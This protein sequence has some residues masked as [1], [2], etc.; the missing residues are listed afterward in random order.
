MTFS[1]R[2]TIRVLA[3]PD[4]RISC[5]RR[6]WRHV[7]EELRLR[8]EGCH[9]SGAFLLGMERRGRLQVTD[10]IFYD[11]LDSNAY[12]TGACV[13]HG[14][15]FGKL[16]AMCRDRD[17]TVVADAHTHPRAAFQSN[18]DRTNPMIARAGHIA[19]IVPDFATTRTSHSALGVYEYRGRH[20]WADWSGNAAKSF[21]YV[22]LWS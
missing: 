16:W 14:D 22:G 4:H 21:F 5:S 2:A 10:A 7:L 6:F 20:E 11:D 12:E 9:E 17:L 1:I 15:A 13:L 3:A 8:G 19:L 18:L